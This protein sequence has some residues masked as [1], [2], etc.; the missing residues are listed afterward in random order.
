M[1]RARNATLHQ[2][3]CYWNSSVTNKAIG[4][5]AGSKGCSDYVES[6]V[7]AI[8][9]TVADL[10]YG[11][12]PKI[13]F[14]NCSGGGSNLGTVSKPSYSYEVTPVGSVVSAVTNSSCGAGAK[15]QVTTAGVVSASCGTSNVSVSGVSVSPASATIS[16]G[17]TTQLA[18]TIA[19]S[20]ATN[21]SVSWSSSNTSITTVN[22]SGLVTGV[23]AGSATI[24]VKTADGSKTATSSITVQTGGTS[25]LA[26]QGENAVINTGV[27]E[28]KNAGYTGT[29]YVNTDN[30]I[31]KY[32]EWT[33]TTNA[34]GSFNIYFRYAS[35]GDRPADVYV[36]GTKVISALAF[37]TT[38]AWTTWTNTATK[39]VTLVNGV[40]KI[41]VTATTSGGC[42]NLDYLQV[43]GSSTLKS[44]NIADVVLETTNANKEMELYPNPVQEAI[45]ISGSLTDKA[46]VTVYVYNQLGSLVTSKNFGIIE[47][48]DFNVSFPADNIKPGLYILKVKMN[49]DIK[50][51]P[52]VK[53]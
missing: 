2:L 28:A 45:N 15:L 39:T 6:G 37:P 53:K 7:F 46:D 27:T 11:G 12:S 16:V 52:F 50:T 26:Y 49:G 25:T 10:S 40:N 44:G 43:T 29:G 1:V 38:T 4:L 5:S 30:A 8:P 22:S 42:A 33:V 34:A 51:I 48:G 20:N 47:S 41:R 24:T 32:V 14:V 19:P 13:A 23:A 21:Q 31:G 17:G 9:G 3:N 18:A 36:N 35:V